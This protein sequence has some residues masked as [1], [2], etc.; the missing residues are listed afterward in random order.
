MTS[1]EKLSTMDIAINAQL[2]VAIAQIVIYIV[3]KAGG[4]ARNCL[5]GVI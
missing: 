3:D 5:F 4:V 1:A 2:F